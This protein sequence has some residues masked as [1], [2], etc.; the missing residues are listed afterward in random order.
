MMPRG[1]AL[2]PLRESLVRNS[3]LLAMGFLALLILVLGPL[4]FVMTEGWSWFDSFYATVISV[5]TVGYG[6]HAPVTF[7]G[8]VVAICV[9]LSG[10]GA[11]SYTLVRVTAYVVEG[12]FNQFLRS[13]QL[14][15]SLKNMKD[16]YIV[17][18][19]GHTG[20]QILSELLREKVPFVAVDINPETAEH[21]L[22]KGQPFLAGDA[23]TDAIL[24]KAGIGHAAGIAAS[25]HDD[26]RNLFLVVTARNL[27]PGIR[28]VAN[29]ME[30]NSGDKM[31]RAGADAV[32]F[33]GQVGA[34]RLANLLLR[35]NVATFIETMI[36]HDRDP[37]FEEFTV[38]PGSP[39]EGMVLG[40]LQKKISFRLS[41]VAI[42][43]GDDRFIYNP[44][45]N[46]S[47]R[48]EDTLVVIIAK[49]NAKEL[50]ASLACGKSSD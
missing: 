48:A 39:C 11:M 20:G 4:G 34:R 32:V 19:I 16:H 45:E 33:T 5:T 30:D 15:Q 37:S 9:V 12:H 21:P 1:D 27:N 8:R 36:R 2:K 31:L 6:D 29:T 42:R 22:V 47:L 17:C 41:P 46:Y 38:P 7:G 26:A 40:D 24:E 50:K 18:G 3:T 44:P 35:P 13:R 49:K 28:I 25:L 23:T 10:L 14:E 43:H